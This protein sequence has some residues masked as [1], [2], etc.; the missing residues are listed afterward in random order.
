MLSRKRNG[1]S[2]VDTMKFKENWKAWFSRCGSQCVV[3]GYGS[4]ASTVDE[5][6]EQFSARFAE[7]N[8]IKQNPTNKSETEK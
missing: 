5:L 7:E 3:N 8:N 2:I 4:L 1:E 6:Y